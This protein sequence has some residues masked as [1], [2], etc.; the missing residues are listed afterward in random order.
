M[1]NHFEFEQGSLTLNWD[2][3]RVTRLDVL[4]L[5][6]HDPAGRHDNG[7]RLISV[8]DLD[9]QA[10]IHAVD[11][12]G[13]ELVIWLTN[14]RQLHYSLARLNQDCLMTQQ[15]DRCWSGKTLWQGD[16]FQVP[17]VDWQDYIGRDDCRHQALAAVAD[18][19]LVLLRGV[20]C[21]PGQVLK[22]IET[23]GFVRE[24][25]YGRLFD[26]KT[27]VS[28][29]NLAFSNLGL[30]P[31]TDNPY[32]D[33]VP[34][35]QLLHCL[36]NEVDGG[37]NLLVDGFRA[38][39][40]LQAEH[41]EAFELLTRIRLPYR[42]SDSQADLRSRVPFI[43]TDQAGK[44]LKVRYNNRSIAPFMLPFEEQ[45]AFYRA[46]RL[47]AETLSA[48]ELALTCRLEPGDCLVFD[49]T[50]VMHART[51]FTDGGRR[52]LQG[53]YSD[54]DGLYSSLYQLGA[55]PC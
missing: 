10:G 15:D 36:A 23:F 7:Q 30:G 47:W 34:G 45:R 43:E 16:D 46:Y 41:P 27:V 54:L 11:R 22:V 35:I 25:N 13:P 28:P 38:A 44:V 20:P 24:T 31:H 51:A 19:G 37:E 55:A 39:A 49:N 52:H 12:Q 33:P 5:Q 32:R 40:R 17:A 50:R 8:L 53:A 14:G 21:E 26:V 1:L 9:W 3:G 4:W 2:D 42:F 48:P 29:S 18:S 6:D